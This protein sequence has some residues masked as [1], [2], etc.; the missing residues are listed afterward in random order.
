VGLGFNLCVVPTRTIIGMS[1]NFGAE[2]R[3]WSR[4]EVGQWLDRDQRWS[5]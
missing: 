5:D 2:V 1:Y 4:T 3:G